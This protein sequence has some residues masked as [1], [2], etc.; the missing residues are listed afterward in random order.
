MVALTGA[1]DVVVLLVATTRS[2]D[3]TAV[4]RRMAPVRRPTDGPLVG[5]PRID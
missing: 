3:T 4:A 2:M 1:A 5:R